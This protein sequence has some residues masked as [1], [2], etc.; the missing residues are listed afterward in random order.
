MSKYVR[1]FS[2]FILFTACLAIHGGAQDNK[3]NPKVQAVLDQMTAAYKSL[4]TLHL[5]MTMKVTGTVP[6]TMTDEMP[7]DVELRFQRPNKVWLNYGEQKKA[8][9]ASRQ[10]VV[11]DGANLWRW[12]SDTNTFTIAKAP[13]VFKEMANLPSASPEFEILFGEEDPFK[14]LPHD[15]PMTLGTPIKINDVD[16]DVLEIAMEAQES[17][18]TF[19]MKL[20]VGQ[21][22]HLVRGM[23]V[24]GKGNDPKTGKEIEFKCDLIYLVVDTTPIFTSSDFIFTPP[25]GATEQSK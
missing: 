1:C 9:I 17:P 25:P 10:Q 12:K 4:N 23:S 15:A 24:F 19:G 11:S 13:R 22:D 14:D 20:M 5:K 3:R 16:V 7:D 8:E 6:P 18:F 2:C 21:Q